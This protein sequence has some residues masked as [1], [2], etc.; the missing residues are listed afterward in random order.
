[1]FLDRRLQLGLQTVL[2]AGG[3]LELVNPAQHLDTLQGQRL[4]LRTVI[5]VQDLSHIV[6]EIQF[7]KRVQQMLP[8]GLKR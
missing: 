6:I 2:R 3:S 5:L 8:F 4:S 7:L 1:M